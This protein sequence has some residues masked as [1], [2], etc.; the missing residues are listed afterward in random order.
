MVF[1]VQEEN[2][3]DNQEIQGTT[4]YKRG[5]PEEIVSSTPDSYSTVVQWAT[6]R[7]MLILQYILG[8]Q[9]KSIDFTNAFTQEDILSG[10]PVFIELPRDFNSDGVQ[11]DFV[12]KSKKSLYVQAEA[13][14]LWYKKL[15]NGLLERVFYDKCG[16]LPVHV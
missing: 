16:S 14:H 15:L 12:L 3:L 13:A 2:W 8:L 7:L 9:S 1:Q 5:Y 6:V 4:L 11:H 10:E